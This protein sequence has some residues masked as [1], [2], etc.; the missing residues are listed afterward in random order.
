MPD[1]N[2][3]APIEIGAE[4]YTFEHLNPFTMRFS[5]I[6]A[7]RTL[8][9]NITFSNHCFSFSP[10]EGGV[11]DDELKLVDHGNRPRIFCPIRY[12]LSKR[13]PEIVRSL[14]NDRCYVWETKTTRNFNYSIEIDDPEGPYH[15][16]MKVTRSTNLKQQEVSVFIE[17]AYHEDP[18]K[19]PPDL[20]GRMKFHTLCSNVYL[21]KKTSTKR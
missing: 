10:A 11:Y 1:N 16:F 6:S 15:L 13:V 14:N 5:S 8:R 7:R 3:F 4:T 12:R 9:V 18:E 19:G 2:Y 20:L 21:C 17:S